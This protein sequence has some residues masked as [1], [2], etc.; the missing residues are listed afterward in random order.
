MLEQRSTLLKVTIW[1]FCRR[2]PLSLR[3]VN[4][5]RLNIV[6]RDMHI[7]E[8]LFPSENMIRWMGNYFS[9]KAKHRFLVFF[10][11]LDSSSI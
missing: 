11:E 10:L 9:I 4:A 2:S 6:K 7:N 8:S 3:G 5:K 1:F